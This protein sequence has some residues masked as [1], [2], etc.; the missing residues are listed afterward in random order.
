MRNDLATMFEIFASLTKRL[1]VDDPVDAK[2]A[3]AT[4][5]RCINW[6]TVGTPRLHEQVSLVYDLRS[7]HG[8]ARG[9]GEEEEQEE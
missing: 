7:E 5:D 1:R 8:E 4:K 6:F 9:E 2:F 3:G